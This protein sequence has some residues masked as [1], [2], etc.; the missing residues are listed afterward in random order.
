MKN[1]AIAGIIMCTAISIF[2]AQRGE[3][4]VDSIIYEQGMQWKTFSSEKPVKAFAVQKDILW[5]A[6]QTGLHMINMAKGTDKKD[7]STIG[8]IPATS[9][10]CLAA[11]ATGELWVG[12]ENGIAMKT[13]DGFKLYTKENG[14]PD[15]TI[16]AIVPVKSGKVWVGTNNGAAC[17][18]SGSWTAYTV[19][20]GLC[21]AKVRG[22]ALDNNGVVWMGTEKG[23]STFNGSKWTTYTMNNGL[24]W[25]DTKAIAC[26]PRTNIIWAAVGEKD[27]NSF[28]GTSWKQYMEV[29]EGAV[30]CIMTDT[31]SR[32][33]LGTT[34]GLVKFNGDEW[35]TD[36][37]KIGIPANQATQM[38]CDAQGNLWF[39]MEKG[40]MRV[41]NPYPY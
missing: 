31:Q 27:I 33:W 28:D 21:G 41:A 11:D 6:A 26:D 23:I 32:I 10:T 34:N 37:Q 16:N 1:S 29:V 18:Q 13:K 2:A 20:Q 35:V 24:S 39:G 19:D 17:F 9:I 14:L 15:N 22:I 36:Q 5:Y 25:N 38:R 40:V 30:K 4:K 8:S 12:T 7:F 3:T